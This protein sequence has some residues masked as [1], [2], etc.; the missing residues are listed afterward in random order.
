MPWSIA[1]PRFAF[2][3]AAVL[4]IASSAPAWWQDK[5]PVPAVRAPDGVYAVLRDSVKEKEILPLKDGEAVVVH[6]QRYLKSDDKQPPRFLVVRVAPDVQPELAEPPKTEKVGDEIVRILLKLQPRAAS[7][8]ERL[9]GE[10]LGKE[11][12]IVIGGEVVTTHKIREVIKGG[13]VQ[14]TNCAPG[15]AKYLLSQ[16]AAWSKPARADDLVV[17]GSGGEGAFKTVQAAINAAPPGTV[18]K[19]TRILIKPGTY[20]EQIKIPKD[21]VYLS[22]IGQGAKPDDVVLTFNL[23]A[24]SAGP[25]GAAVGTGGSSST[26]ISANDFVAENV[27]FANSTPPKIAQAVAIRPQ[28]DRM[29]FRNC[30][31]IGF[32]DTLYP[33][34]GRQYYKDCYITGTVDFIFGDATAVFDR[35]TIHSS[36]R[37]Y[38]TAASTPQNAKF[39]FVFLDCTLTASGAAAKANSVYLGRPWRPHSAV[40]FVRCKMGPHIYGV[41]WDNW[42]DP[43]NEATARYAEFASMDPDGKL[44]DVSKRV[45]WSR[46]LAPEQARELTIAHVLGG[47]D[48]WDPLGKTQAP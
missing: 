16:L 41:G 31:F 26:I 8:L 34:V 22:L 32:Q 44:V 12:A 21:K 47:A 37:G 14:I 17:D 28:A 20:T 33:C 24:K 15:S 45:G 11:I 4:V 1:M 25:K 5:T 3:V 10:R 39:G 19:R 7:A 46:Q 43:A 40:A 23:H 29:T 18:Q 48:G 30:R 35:C 9:T 36:D 6:N 38:I 13:E 2:L 27:T 42:R